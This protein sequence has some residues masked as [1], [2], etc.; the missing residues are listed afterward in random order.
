MTVRLV[1]YTEG[2]G[3]QIVSPFYVGFPL[4]SAVLPVKQL[5][6]GGKIDELGQAMRE[7]QNGNGI[8]CQVAD[9]VLFFY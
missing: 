4:N 5:G 7:K 2:S 3:K 8:G 1:P 9:V 6:T